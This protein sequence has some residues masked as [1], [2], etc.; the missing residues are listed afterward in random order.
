M[1]KC[2]DID[3]VLKRNG[4]GQGERFVSQLEPS[5]FELNDFDIE[6][7][8]LFTYNFAKHVNY[9]D[10]ENSA[11]I[12]GD[13]QDFFNCFDFEETTIPFRA[14]R[15]YARQKEQITTALSNFKAAGTLTPHLTLFVCFLQ[16]LEQSKNRFNGLTKRHLDFY[17][18]NIL[19]VDKRAATPDN[20]HVIFELAKKSIEEQIVVNTE[21]N[22]KPDANGNQRIYTTDEELIANQAKVAS[23]KTVYTDVSLQ[24][25]KASPN[26]KTLDGFEEPLPED[27]P[28]WLPFGYTS[29]EK[30]YTELPDATIGFAV[31]SPLL[32][33]QEG[34]RT[35]QITLS[36]APETI[37]TGH[38]LTDFNTDILK[39]V[40]S[41]NGSGSEKWVD[42]IDL[43]EGEVEQEVIQGET[44]DHLILSFQL[45]KDMPAIMPY[46]DVFLLEK[47]DTTFPVIR[48]L[49]DTSKQDGVSFH[50][51]TLN[52]SLIAIKVFVDVQEASTIHIENDNGV[53]KANKPFF[54]FTPQPIKNANFYIN[55]EEVFAKAWNEITVNFS[56]KNTPENGFNDW[57]DAYKK[58]AIPGESA[59]GVIVENDAH[60]TALKEILHK[61]NWIPD[62]SD[63]QVLFTKEEDTS[64]YNCAVQIG[65]TQGFEVDKTGPIRLRLNTSF[66]HDLFPKLYASSLIG[67]TTS[68]VVSTED[69]TTITTSTTEGNIPNAPYTPI[70]ENITVNYN[71]EETRSIQSQIVPINEVTTVHPLNTNDAHTQERI[72]LFHIHPF[73][74]CEEHTYLKLKRYQKG[75]RDVYDKSTIHSYLVPKYCDG[76]ELFIGLKDAQAQQNIA[77]LVQVL[78][79]SENPQVTSFAEREEIQWAVLCDNQWKSLTNDILSNSTGNF[80]SSGIVKFGLPRQ[81]TQDNTRLPEGYIWIRAKMHRAYNAIC[82]AIDIHTQAVLATFEDRNN[83]LA[84]LDKGLAAET[85]KKLITRIPQVKGVSQPYTS[86]NGIPEESDT[87]FYRRISER[88]RHKNRAIT[89]WDYEHLILQ[90][91]PEVFKVKCLNHT[92]IQDENDTTKDNYIAA[93]HVTLVVIP[94]SVNKNVFDIYQPRVSKGLINKIKAFINQHNT[95]QVTADVINPRYEEV[96]VTLEVEFLKGYDERF[97]SKQLE[98]DI[99]KFL[100]P[101]A[102]DTHQEVV[103]GIDLHRSVLIDY[104]EK[105]PYVDYL[106]NVTIQK[107]TVV[108]GNVVTPSNPRSI[109]V[110]AKS[111][112]I[113]TV[114]TPC[115]DNNVQ[116]KLIC[117]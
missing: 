85:I 83:E 115:G 34:T 81:V 5:H 2:N 46:D 57:Y 77:L 40:I 86:F 65:N 113:S 30:K 33:L 93:G 38:R 117:Q 35:V 61:E 96:A 105:L 80:L 68:T 109:L 19:Q 94:D 106:Q 6:D 71:A 89:L 17:Y 76:G 78:E 10:T 101:W 67:N 22:G 25:I 102:F 59:E 27:E 100:S 13:W 90:E 114:L 21:L 36:F 43:T 97:Y 66:L 79:G 1:G 28:Y 44:I 91:F 69:N 18:K 112:N 41:I 24:E 37:E 60:F 88:L 54:P 23:L 70:A 87:R 74:Q 98:E 11:A 108:M 73:G 3:N 26:A 32:L 75:I 12:K 104:I 110:S 52:R 116:E 51:A 53:L 92:Y 62:T 29:E 84:H 72:Q 7:W 20:V 58:N 4:T 111:H 42:G 63:T 48:F 99:I 16:L 47:Y 45:N 50:R 9:F 56:W 8:L 64:V 82:K 31:A 107:D 49:I 103:F 95:S 14:S 39:N 55:Y 15:T